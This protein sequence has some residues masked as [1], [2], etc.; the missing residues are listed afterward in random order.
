MDKKL[1]ISRMSRN[2]DDLLTEINRATCS[3]VLRKRQQQDGKCKHRPDTIE[4]D[5]QIHYNKK[6][7]AKK[8]STAIYI[9]LTAALL[10]YVIAYRYY[11]HGY[12]FGARL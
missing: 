11:Q 12:V 8:E 6:E 9:G 2:Y 5:G 10:T 7:Y 4:K 1:G 3:S